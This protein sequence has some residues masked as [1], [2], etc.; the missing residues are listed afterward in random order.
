MCIPG[1]WPLS[2]NTLRVVDCCINVSIHG[3]GPSSLKTFL[4]SPASTKSISIIAHNNES[5]VNG[6]YPMEQKTTTVPP[7]KVLCV[8]L[9][10]EVSKNCIFFYSSGDF[11]LK[12]QP[13]TVVGRLSVFTESSSS[14]SSSYST[15]SSSPGTIA[16]ALASLELCANW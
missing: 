16:I 1:H 2:T 10:A 4:S 8:Q 14:I 13:T 3:L 11:E 6:Y 15:S 7:L 9:C 12:L 5:D